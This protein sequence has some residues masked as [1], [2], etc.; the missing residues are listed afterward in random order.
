MVSCSGIQFAPPRSA[1]TC[2]MCLPKERCTEQHS[3][4]R[5]MPLFSDAHDGDPAPQ[6]P[7]ADMGWRE[8][9]DEDTDEEAAAEAVDE[10]DL[11]FPD[12]I[13]FACCQTKYATTVPFALSHY[14]MKSDKSAQKSLQQ[15]VIH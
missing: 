9:G 11:D 13:S 8:T 5:R 1:F 3:E 6:S 4:Q 12:S 10:G 2:E 14:L 7:Q 15:A